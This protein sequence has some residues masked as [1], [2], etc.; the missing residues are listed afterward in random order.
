MSSDEQDLRSFVAHTADCDAHL[1]GS[2]KRVSAYLELI[3][4]DI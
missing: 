2:N 1:I 4:I 3:E